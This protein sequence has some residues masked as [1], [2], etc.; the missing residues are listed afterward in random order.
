MAIGLGRMFGFKIQENFNYP[1]IACSLT[2]F[3]RRWH[4]SLSAWFRDYLFVPLNVAPMTERIRKKI[5]EGNYKTNYR[6]FF[7]IAMVFTLCG[8]WHGAGYNFIAWGMLH[9]II[10][11]LESLWLGTVIKK[12][13]A[14]LQHA[15]LLFIVTMSWVLFRSPGVKSA[16]SYFKALAGFT[17]TN[18]LYYHT[19]LYLNTELLFVLLAGVVGAA[20]FSKVIKGYF[21][22]DSM[23]RLLPFAEVAFI[24]MIL[25]ASFASL[26]GSTF[27]PFIY[28]KF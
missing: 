12:W 27:S 26:A 18:S 24:V 16:S 23:Q 20:P 21:E 22:R 4:I 7:S 8:F 1:Y 6:G 14:P 13:K 3:W 11:G 17:S 5:G 2:D 28:Q 25:L 15:Y 19:S 10:L 9:G